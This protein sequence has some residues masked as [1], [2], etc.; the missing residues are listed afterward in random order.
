M[1]L[2]WPTK[3][4]IARAKELNLSDDIGLEQTIKDFIEGEKQKK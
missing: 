3:Y 4:D 2:S 1:V